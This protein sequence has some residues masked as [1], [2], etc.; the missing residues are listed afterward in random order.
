MSNIFELRM[1]I[2]DTMAGIIQ[3]CCQMDENSGNSQKE[4]RKKSEK[5]AT[6]ILDSLGFQVISGPVAQ[7]RVL[8]VLVVPNK[9]S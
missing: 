5:I 9:E 2:A 3:Q 1:A 8:G 4:L 6:E 7:N